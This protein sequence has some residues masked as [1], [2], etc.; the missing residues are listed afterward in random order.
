MT[1]VLIDPD[2]GKSSRATLADG[3]VNGKHTWRHC[4]TMHVRADKTMMLVVGTEKRQ[5]VAQRSIISLFC[6]NSLKRIAPT[7]V[8][9]TTTS[10]Y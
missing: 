8:R 10:D 4:T 7:I 1:I 5:T 9:L 2:N 6:W 3:C